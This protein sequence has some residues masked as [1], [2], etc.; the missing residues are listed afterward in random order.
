MS[1]RSSIL[2]KIK[3]GKPAYQDLLEVDLSIFNEDL[4]LLEEFKRK[5]EIVGGKVFEAKSFFLIPDSDILG[6]IKR[7]VLR[8]KVKF[9]QILP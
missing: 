4:D 3:A 7:S 2:S 6:T 8:Y 1:S 9:I 5:V